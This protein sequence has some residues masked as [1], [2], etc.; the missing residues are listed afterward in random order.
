MTQ[1]GR[2]RSLFEQALGTPDRPTSEG[3]MTEQVP[4][5]VRED[6]QSHL[7]RNWKEEWYSDESR[8]GRED[9]ERTIRRLV[10][11]ATEDKPGVDRQVAT[12]LLTQEMMG[13]GPIDP[14]L[15]DPEVTEVMVNAP[16]DVWVERDGQLD[17][18][19]VQFTSEQHVR[20]VIL[21]IVG[22]VGRNVNEQS[23]MVD[24]RLPDKSRV[25]AI[26][27]PLALKGSS[28]TI[29]KFTE[30]Y[31]LNDLIQF[32][33]L[34]PTIAEFLKAAVQARASVVVS[35]GTGSGKTTMLNVLSNFISERERIVSI[36]DAA[37]LQLRQPHQVNLESRPANAEGKGEVSIRDLVRNAL[38]MRPDRI[39]VGEVRGGEAADMIDAM[40]TGHDGSLTT[41]H[42]NSPSDAMK[43]LRNLYMRSEE[44]P[45]HV[46][47]NDLASAID[48][49][50][51]TRR[52]LQD[53]S[54]KITSVAEVG[55]VTAEGIETHPIFIYNQTG[56]NAD[57]QVLGRFKATGYVPDVV[58][59]IEKN[60]IRVNLDWFETPECVMT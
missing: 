39:I 17:E 53:G 12:N 36:E 28:L 50:V 25:N 32:Q 46:I 45:A 54:R 21:R 42:A 8:E 27:P 34:N 48:L 59:W 57:G 37:E 60:G 26:I 58:D 5:E 52:F 30:H 10:V 18:T 41:V 7:L 44:L 31:G 11:R 56:V 9:L 49:V 4:Q 38:R 15:K 19:D 33:S 24:A 51:Q 14:L 13:Y 35:G 55:D 1:N 47:D 16:D 20:N 43:R 40:N 3:D 2:G 6:V 23:P 22:A 29:R